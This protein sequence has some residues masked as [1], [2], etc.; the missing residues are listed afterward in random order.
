MGVNGIVR[1]EHSFLPFP[2]KPQVFVPP[3]FGG[4]GGNKFRFN[5]IFVK[6][7]KIPLISPFFFSFSRKKYS[8]HYYMILLILCKVKLLL[9]VFLFLLSIA[10]FGYRIQQVRLFFFGP[11]VIRCVFQV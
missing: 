2:S 3:K 9:L 6:I 10:I 1:R 8:Y 11:P 4:M 5:E 7:P